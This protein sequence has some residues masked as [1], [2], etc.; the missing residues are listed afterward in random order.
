MKKRCN[1]CVKPQLCVLLMLITGTHLI[2]TSL[3]LSSLRMRSLAP[4]LRDQALNSKIWSH[5]ESIQGSVEENE[6]GAK[7]VN[8]QLGAAYGC[9]SR[10]ALAV[11]TP[12]SLI[13]ITRKIANNSSKQWQVCVHQRGRLVKP[14]L[15]VAAELF[16]IP[17]A[18]L[19]TS[20]GPK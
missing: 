15:Q 9:K 10:N 17:R 6:H 14:K 12:N 7:W 18:S 2:M 16:N 1:H 4:Q 19:Q 20:H 11:K 3:S 5:S 13:I 8:K